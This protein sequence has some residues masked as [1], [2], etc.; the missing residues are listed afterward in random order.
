MKS[1]QLTSDIAVP[2][3]RS[4]NI[5]LDFI[6]LIRTICV[7]LT[8]RMFILSVGSSVACQQFFK[9]LTGSTVLLL[10]GLNGALCAKT[11]NEFASLKFPFTDFG[12]FF[13]NMKEKL[14]II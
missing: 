12:I 5:Y 9:T 2:T 1:S 4:P 8:V 7:K 14:F 6:A 3:A 10:I 13:V 11:R